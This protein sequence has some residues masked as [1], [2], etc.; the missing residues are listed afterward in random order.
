MLPLYILEPEYWR[1]PDT[2][3]RQWD[4]TARSLQDLRAGLA[5]L[6]VTLALRSGDAAEVLDRIC[7]R[8]AITRIVSHEETGNQMDLC[9]RPAGSRLGAGQWGGMD[10][11]P[12]S[13]VIRPPANPDGWQARR[14]Q[15]IAAPALPP[16]RCRASPEW[17]PA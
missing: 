9:P 14:D 3:A 11:L 15:F 12:Q 17:S 2:S 16:P 7:R 1:L 5:R 6:G 13:C 8:H 10:R 4:F